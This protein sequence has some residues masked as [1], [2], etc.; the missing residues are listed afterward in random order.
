MSLIRGQSRW[1]KLW[2]RFIQLSI[3]SILW[4]W[5]GANLIA[6][7]LTVV[8][9]SQVSLVFLGFEQGPISLIKTFSVF[10]LSLLSVTHAEIFSRSQSYLRLGLFVHS[11]FLYVNSLFVCTAW[12]SGGMARFP[13]ASGLWRFSPSPLLRTRSFKGLALP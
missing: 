13:F 6:W 7:S 5:A 10:S 12:D 9:F 3:F 11:I 1:F 4:V 8:L 2:C